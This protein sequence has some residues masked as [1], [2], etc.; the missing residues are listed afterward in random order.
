MLNVEGTRLPTVGD[1]HEFSFHWAT[2]F[3]HTRQ[4][5]TILPLLVTVVFVSFFCCCDCVLAS[6]ISQT[7]LCFFFLKFLALFDFQFAL[8]RLL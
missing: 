1:S 5:T 3:L 7:I 8:T 6:I 2:A 4:S